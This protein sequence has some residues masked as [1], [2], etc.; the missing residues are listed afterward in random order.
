M[1][2]LQLGFSLG[3]LQ[4][5]PHYLCIVLNALYMQVQEKCFKNIQKNAG[6]LFACHPHAP[7]LCIEDCN[8]STRP[9][10]SRFLNF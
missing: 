7:S 5:P 1:C 10:P 4:P 8:K 9:L 6:T 3:V 2:T